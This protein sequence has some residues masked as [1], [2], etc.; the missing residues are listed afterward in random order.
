[1]GEKDRKRD[2]SERERERET[3]VGERDTGEIERERYRE[4]ER[5]KK[6][7]ISIGKNKEYKKEKIFYMDVLKTIHKKTSNQKM[8]SKERD[9]SIPEYA[10]CMYNNVHTY[11]VP[12]PRLEPLC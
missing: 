7:E 9:K 4:K 8:K 1:M 3:G 5:K 11:K 2:K 10:Q 6:R 12:G